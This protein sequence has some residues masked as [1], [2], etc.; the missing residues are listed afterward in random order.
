[1]R[2]FTLFHSCSK[3]PT[4]RSLYISLLLFFWSAIKLSFFVVKNILLNQALLFP[5]NY[6]KSN[7]LIFKLMCQGVSGGIIPFIIIDG[8]QPM[9]IYFYFNRFM[10]PGQPVSVA[11]FLAL[12]FPLIK[13]FHFIIFILFKIIYKIFKFKII[14]KYLTAYEISKKCQFLEI[15]EKEDLNLTQCI[16][17]TWIYISNY[18]IKALTI[19]NVFILTIS[20]FFINSCLV[21]MKSEIQS[22]Q[23]YSA[24]W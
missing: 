17:E 4:E 10:I 13:H 5:E 21:I 6:E 19:I 16:M 14:E 2:S 18:I 8:I 15:E 23:I 9:L 3:H 22:D 1:V 20:T 12:I 24:F 7:R 11:G